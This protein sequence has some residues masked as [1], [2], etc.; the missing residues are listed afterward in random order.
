MEVYSNSV[1]DQLID[2]L[3]YKLNSGSSYI[4][5]RKSVTFFPQGSNIYTPQSG[6]RVMRFLVNG[7]DWLDSTNSLRIFFDIRNNSAT[8]PLRVLG[9]PY[10]FI[11][12]MR[13]LCQNVLVEDLD[14]ANRN[15][16]MFDIMRARHVRENEDDEGSGE[17]RFDAPYYQPLFQSNVATATSSGTANVVYP[18]GQIANFSNTYITVLPGQ[19]RTVSFKPLSGLLNCGKLLPLQYCPI[20][21]E[22]EVVSSITDPIISVNDAALSI[23]VDGTAG[24]NSGTINTSLTWQIEN[25]QIKADICVLDN[26]LNNEYAALLLSG[27]SLPINYC[28]YVC[29]LQSVSGQTPSINITRGFSRLKS[30]F[31]T[32]D[33]TNGYAAYNNNNT[34]TPVWKKIWN[35]FIHPM[36]FGGGSYNSDYEIQ[37]A[38]MQLGS[39]TYPEYPMSSVAECFYQLRKTMGVEN[40]N[41]HSLDITPYEFRN[42][43]FALA[44]DTEKNLGSA[45]TG[46]NTKSGSLL[47]VK[48]KSTAN[49][50]NMPDTIYVTM[51]YD[52]I[53]QVSDASVSVF[54]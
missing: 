18:Y 25:P 19:S 48:L 22:L 26:A 17:A 54:D 7:S 41:F 42:H 35:D 23:N 10:S 51:H 14:Y 39:K 8:V 20:T 28:S 13:V 37:S 3:S 33:Q 27:K 47:T 32:L 53:L 36:T 46:V 34:H 1:E 38:Q 30:V 15:H 11:R 45:F 31:V 49:S 16:Y 43:K 6:T 12:R 52:G 50:T 4:T 5:D 44:F 40:S 9:G 2:G 24:F 29:Q 21:I